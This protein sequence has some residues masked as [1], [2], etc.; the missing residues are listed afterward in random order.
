MKLKKIERTNKEEQ[1]LPMPKGKL[2]WRTEG[3]PH[4]SRFRPATAKHDEWM[5][6]IKNS[7][8]L[9]GNMAAYE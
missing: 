2:P 4:E 3:A 8:N 1:P 7:V 5:R 9:H 6:R